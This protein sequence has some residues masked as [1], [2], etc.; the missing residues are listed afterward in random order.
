MTRTATTTRTTTSA[1]TDRRARSGP[2]RAASTS[3]SRGIVRPAAAC[4][5]SQ[6]SS[7]GTFVRRW[8]TAP[9]LAPTAKPVG[10]RSRRRT[11]PVRADQ[12]HDPG[13]RLRLVPPLDDSTCSC[14]E[15]PHARGAHRRQ[16]RS[17]LQA[18]RH[19]SR[20][21]FSSVVRVTTTAGGGVPSRDRVPAA[22]T[23][24]APCESTRRRRTP[25]A[26]ASW[27]P[28]SCWHTSATRPP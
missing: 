2:G 21:H 28:R 4:D 13:S 10:R 22:S 5:V 8:L 11:R 23:T 15:Q 17:L 1:I 25:R 20:G 14:D 7:V 24:T 12:R 9:E 16:R 18:R 3:C 26:S 27:L 19:G 6:D